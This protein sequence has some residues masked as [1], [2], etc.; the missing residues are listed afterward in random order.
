[1]AATKTQNAQPQL[2]FV[3][4][5]FEELAAEMADYLK[6]EEAKQ[7]LANGDQASKDDVLA[8][9]VAAS[10]SLNTV[11]EK[12][13]T[14]A[15]NLLVHL[16][17]QASDPKK[18]L[19]AL[20]GVFAKPLANSPVH[21]PGLSLNGLTT[22]F[23]LLDQEDP[24]RARVFL[25]IVKF[26]RAHGMYD[27]L[28]PYMDKIGAWIDDWED[29]GEDYQRKL[30]E[31]VAEAAI[32]AGEE[33][34]GYEF[35][36]KALRS[37]DAD[38]KEEVTSEDAQ[39]LSLRAVKMALLSNNHFLFQELRAI[40]SVQALSDSQP[41]YSQ[42]LDIFAEQDLE[43]YSDFN[44]EHE[45]WLEEQQLDH[46]KLHRKIRLLTFASLAAATPSR[47][48]EYS[49]IA[50]ALQIPQ[51]EVERWAIDV[52]RAGLLEGKLSQQRGVF[53]V[54]KATYRVFGQKQYQELASRVDHWR[55]TLQNVLGVLRQEQ[56][57]AKAQKE[58]EVQEL[59]RKLANAG[60]SG[61]G[62]RQGGGPGGRRQQRERTDN[63]D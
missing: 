31:E 54:H 9:L 60:V 35:I 58:R 13:F 57:N 19:Q 26:V 55:S 14:A 12:E 52:I 32:E 27:T 30:Y 39:R 36:L 25:E 16:V 53:L 15:S 17:L 48:I 56:V 61:E 44:D 51:E 38:E 2:L 49:R 1:M 47:E 20:C 11:P 6:A 62:G 42:L 59:E 37:F 5:S 23:N 45:G 41:V 29:T 10:Q 50:K 43:D 63:D 33:E 8:K 46:E 28:R 18:Y 40:P 34:Q 3:D 7:L 21:G 22:V 24:V 4:G